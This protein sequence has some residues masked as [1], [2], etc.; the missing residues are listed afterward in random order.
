L[1]G[2]KAAV[3]CSSSGR[4]S[5]PAEGCDSAAAGSLIDAAWTGESPAAGSV[6]G[7][8]GATVPDG[9]SG[10]EAGEDQTGGHGSSAAGVVSGWADDGS[11]VSGQPGDGSSAAGQAGIDG[12]Q[13][14]CCWP[15]WAGVNPQPAQNRPILS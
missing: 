5:E 1:P 13:A 12:R 6:T 2:E 7:H 10:G 11:P 3:S 15:R 14:A 4:P 8:G 9:S